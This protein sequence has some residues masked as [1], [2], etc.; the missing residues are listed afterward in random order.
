MRKV[1]KFT[2][3]LFLLLGIL[4]LPIYPQ[5]RETGSIQGSV[6]TDT[7]EIL[8][9]VEVT[10]SSPAMMGSQSRIT[11]ERGKYR[12]PNCPPGTYSVEV[13]LQ[14]FT[15]QRRENVKIEVEQ[16]LIVDFALIIGSLEEKIEVI[17]RAPT[18]D[19]RDSQTGTTSMPE[20]FLEQIPGTRT[21]RDEMFFAPGSYGQRAG[22]YGDA[23]RFVSY[24]GSSV[25]SAHNF[26]IDGVTMNSPEAGEH[27]MDLDFGAIEEMKVMGLGAPA[28]YGGFSGAV[29]HTVTKSGGNKLGGSLNFYVQPA[30]W[31]SENWG[32]YP[33]LISK[34]FPEEYDLNFNLAGPITKDKLWFYVG[35]RY[36]NSRKKIE[37]YEGV[38]PY[39]VNQRGSGKLSWQPNPNNRF[40]AMLEY[41]LWEGHHRGTGP[42]YGPGC[43]HEYVKNQLYYNASYLHVFSDTTFMDVK[44]GGYY[45][46]AYK[47][48]DKDIPPHK[49]LVTKMKTGNFEWY[50]D[51]PR[52]RYQASSSISHHADEFLKGSHD[53]KIGV[54]VEISPIGTHRGWGGGKLYIDQA[55]E[56]YQMWTYDGY[57]TY[58]TTKRISAFVQD[59]WTIGRLSINSGLRMN[60]WRGDIK[61]Y[62]ANP[63]FAPKLG[64]APRI[65]IS[66]DVFGDH[67][68]AFKIH[69][70]KYYHPVYGI[71][72]L[73][74]KPQ[75]PRAKYEW[76]DNDWQLQYEDPWEEKYKMDPDLKWTYM[77]QFVVGVER[78]VVKDLSIEAQFIYKTNHDFLDRVNITGMWEP[79]QWVC[80]DD[81]K[82]YNVYQRLNPGDNK[83]LLTNPEVGKDIGAAFPDIVGI[84]PSRSYR[85][86]QLGFTKRYSNGWML[87]GSYLYGKAWGT[88]DNS[89]YDYAA[90]R[91]TSFGASVT[92]SN[93]NYQINADGELIL[94]PTHIFKLIGS[95]DVPVVNVIFGFFYSFTSGAN[96]SREIVL[97]SEIDPDPVSDFQE[98]IYLY[99]DKRGSYSYPGLH[100]LD[101]RVEKFFDFGKI[102]LSTLLDVFNV[103]NSD[104]VVDAEV[105]DDPRS[106]FPFGYVWGIREARTF[107]AGFKLQF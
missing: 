103:F 90:T 16:T 84:D 21:L 34:K 106:D 20:E 17:A 43:E 92:Y 51:V 26:M 82:T 48:I 23:T 98:S 97:P 46:T 57:S 58:P 31:H 88:D 86:F 3:I 9:G 15:P 41:N 101:L 96:Y 62:D 50:W 99:A 74:L 39:S 73:H 89:W 61:D 83:F 22:W 70:G 36:K 64:I 49:D 93:P 68:T 71:L 27:E 28:E 13:R 8:P 45:Q 87:S 67:T 40:S 52:Q 1:S 4:H 37:G 78:E 18:I 76:I 55:G 66:Y 54:E 102:R 105:Y 65:G 63:A 35:G 47:T 53:F 79:V 91:N 29:I 25:S 60:H 11:N 94:S 33:Y 80:P 19:V 6:T 42:L 5:S 12:F 10:I 81:G 100:N 38:I 107:R 7:A 72:Y 2:L 85:G 30:R 56:P 59:T 77:N 104:T 69:Y 32:S 95:Y 24:Y 14:G 44:F 75:G